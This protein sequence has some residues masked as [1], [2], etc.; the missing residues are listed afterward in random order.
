[1]KTH[2]SVLFFLGFCLLI[3]CLPY[4]SNG[5]VTR[6]RGIVIDKS[7]NEPIPFVNITFKG[8]T[9]G[10]I[11]SFDGTFFLE[12]RNPSDSLSA[13]YI[14]YK[15]EANKI[16]KGAFQE[17]KIVLEPES[18]ALT[19]IVINP[20]ENPAHPILRSI[21]A[22]KEKNDPLSVESFQYEIYNKMEMDINN[23]TEEYKNKKAFKQFKFIF[24]YVDT[25]A[26]TGKTF[27]PVFIIETLSDFSYQS[28]P[29]KKK[30]EIKANKI[31]GV[32]NDM[33]S[34]F[35]GQMYLDFNIYDNYLPIMRQNLVSPISRFGLLSYKYYLIDSAF[36]GDSWCY[37]ISFKPRRKQEA[38]FTG[39]FWVNDTTYALESYKISMSKDMN[40]NFVEHFI[41][42]QT[43]EKVNDSIWF[44]K[45]QDLFIDFVVSNKE[46][47]FFGRKT[48]SYSNIILNPEFE[49]DFFSGQ[50]AEETVLL[51]DAN[52]YSVN[53]WDDFR[54]ETL[55][56][57][58]NDIYKM[59][60]S[61]QE[62][63]LYNSIVNLITTFVTGYWVKGPIEIGPYYTLFSY[64]PIEGA[65]FKF[66]AQTSNAVSTKFQI[67]G[68][69]AYGTID[70]KFKYGA[71][72]LYVFNKNP[73]R[74]L[75][76]EHKNDYEQLGVTDNAFLSDNIL[77]SVLAREQNDKLTKVNS[78][79]IFYEHEWF[80]GVSNTI[81]FATKHVYSSPTVPFVYIDENQ[82]TIVH[83]KLATA[84][85][86]LNTRIAYNEK[87]ILGEFN[88]MSLGTI[89]PIINVNFT[90]GLQGIFG[91]EYNYSKI[92]LN[93]SDK[94][95]INPLGVLQF[96]IDVGKIFGDAPYPFMQLHE[97]NQTYAFDDYAF[98]LM[99]YYEFVSNQYVSLMVENHFKGALLN[100]VPL[101]RRLKW[102]E[103]VSIKMLF[104]ELNQRTEDY[105][106]FP[107]D[108]DDL[109]K[110]YM[111]A[112]VGIENI[113]KFFRVDA[114]WRLTYLD[115]ED[116]LPFG[117]FV[118]MQV[119]F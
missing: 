89:Y 114:I 17:F 12:T 116:V 34:D 88:R 6:V 73:R 57:R 7:N 112:G 4:T 53:D 30:E 28:K 26:V 119:R 62:V 41:A 92:N 14:G 35:T 31:S 5:Q 82:D 86:K 87:F 25:S 115:K 18:I 37:N 99:N 33:I 96:N 51:D 84:E 97:G 52:N 100:H 117:V 107:E 95:P 40:I 11:T 46:Y 98:N 20:G 101:F 61:I 77:S 72:A 118:K 43:Y 104:G 55:T 91:S 74:S 64:N 66:G 75:G 29:K 45:K 50:L 83:H 90:L 81:S 19:E 44:P 108:L 21:I 65:R 38:T 59:V 69:I 49:P 54:H 113:F 110:P 48:T 36:R 24:D 27:L 76:I 15:P 80:Q 111:E 42:E 105:I 70:K 106:A 67:G 63:P 23:I 16:K 102:R 93:L 8:T 1:M 47:G 39:N 22:N 78:T 109:D 85:I 3:I 13:S 56:K 9:I 10:T 94:I 103:I 68:H 2:F 58:E 32:E 60:D 79:K 71:H